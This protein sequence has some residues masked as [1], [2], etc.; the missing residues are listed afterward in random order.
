MNKTWRFL[1]EA[2]A[3]VALIT[4]CCYGAGLALEAPAGAAERLPAKARTAPEPMPAVRVVEAL[5]LV[6][7]AEVLAAE[8]LADRQIDARTAQRVAAETSIPRPD[9]R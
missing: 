9:R 4:A 1:L 3:L 2:L 7:P 6:E 8:G 5:P